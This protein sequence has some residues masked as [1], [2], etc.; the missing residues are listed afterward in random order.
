MHPVIEMTPIGRVA[1]GR[2]EAT[3]DG[4]GPNRCSLMLDP[5]RFGPEALAG[6]EALSHLEVLF[7]FHV[8]VD[9]PLETGARHPR[10]RT[11]WPSVGI[12]AQR[13]RMRPNRI[14]AS[15]CRVLGVR[16]LEVEVEGLDAVDGTPV[17]DIKPVWAEYLPRGELRQPDW[18]HE[19]MANYW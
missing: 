7:H 4:W 5:R 13:G 16:G 17:L 14:G 8:A 6:V 1:G 19:L 18:S 11:D 10:G 15:F 3:K 9:E 2:R 12:F